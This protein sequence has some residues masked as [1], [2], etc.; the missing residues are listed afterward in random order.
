MKEDSQLVPRS[1][2]P[3]LP[4][5]RFLLTESPSEEAV[6]MD[7]LFVGGGPAG[8]AGAIELSRLAAA[9]G[10]G[11]SAELE[12]GVLEKSAG[13]GEHCLSGAVVDPTPFRELF[14]DVPEAELPFRGPVTGDRVYLLSENGKLRLPAPPSMRNHGNQVASICEIVR[15]MGE[16]AEE[17]GVNVFTGFP[18]DALLMDGQRVVGCRTTPGGLDREGQPGSGYV[19]PTDLTARVT[20]LAEGTRG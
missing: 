14:P 7:V 10:E 16:R 9:H 11:A 20:V 2:Q 4:V 1:Y 13:L 6:P 12:V 19:P 15:W 3:D 8:L 18:V 5:E 17:A